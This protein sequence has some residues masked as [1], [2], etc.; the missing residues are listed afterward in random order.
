MEV[1]WDDVYG[2]FLMSLTHV[3][4]NKW[5][6]L[7]KW[8]YVEFEPLIGLLSVI[9]HTGAQWAKEWFDKHFTWVLEKF[10]LKQYGLPL[11]CDYT[12]RQG[13]FDR[14]DGSRRAE[15]FH[16]P[17]HLMLNLL[18]VERMIERNGGVSHHFD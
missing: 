17:R 13:T 8:A 10:P 16:H 3:D 2:G 1:A 14:G 7:V 5:L 9:E 12:T 4:N 6:D 18:A 15:N 11:W